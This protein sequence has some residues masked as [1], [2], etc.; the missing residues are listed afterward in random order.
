MR[1]V[2]FA[3]FPSFEFSKNM[4]NFYCFFFT[5]KSSKISRSTF[6]IGLH[7]SELP[8]LIALGQFKKKF[9]KFEFLE[10]FRE[11]EKVQVQ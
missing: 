9:S 11:L 10:E 8:L 7:G 1:N 4:I 5:Q 6:E 3:E 2:K